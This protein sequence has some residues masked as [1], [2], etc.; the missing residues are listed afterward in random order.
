MIDGQY[1]GERTSHE[2][3]NDSLNEASENWTG[4]KSTDDG[5]FLLEI[6]G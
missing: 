5:I 1:V 2:W 6:D 4:G 3:T